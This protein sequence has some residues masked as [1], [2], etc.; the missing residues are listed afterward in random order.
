[1]SYWGPRP[2]TR[3][4]ARERVEFWSGLVLAEVSAREDVSDYGEM[5]ALVEQLWGMLDEVEQACEAARRKRPA[6][7]LR[8]FFT[9]VQDA[10]VDDDGERVVGESV[11]DLTRARE[12]LLKARGA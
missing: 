6:Q 9:A 4:S 5:S 12:R 10:R 2:S 1:M 8:A 7:E 3:V 11:E